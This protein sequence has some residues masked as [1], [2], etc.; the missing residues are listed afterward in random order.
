MNKM[1]GPD[2][3]EVT[4]FRTAVSLDLGGVKCDPGDWIVINMDDE[5]R[6]M[7][8][9][10]FTSVFGKVLEESGIPKEMYDTE[11]NR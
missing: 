3:E 10:H 5:A 4:F 7:C 1:I 6:A 9:E 8:H 2:G 11:K